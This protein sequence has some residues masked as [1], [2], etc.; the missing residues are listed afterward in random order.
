MYFDKIS[1]AR[2]H[3]NLDQLNAFDANYAKLRE[4]AKIEN[5]S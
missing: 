3:P 1:G 4:D 5:S 2:Q